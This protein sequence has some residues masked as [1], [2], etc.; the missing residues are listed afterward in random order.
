MLEGSVLSLSLLLNQVLLGSLADWAFNLS[1]LS[2]FSVLLFLYK[3]SYVTVHVA[4]KA[5]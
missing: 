1:F 5:R 3:T 4:K 2:D